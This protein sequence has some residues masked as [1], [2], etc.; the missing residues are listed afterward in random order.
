LVRISEGSLRI[1][2]A[3]KVVEAVGCEE[4]RGHY[5]GYHNEAHDGDPYKGLEPGAHLGTR[6]LL[7]PACGTE[8]GLIVQEL[9]EEGAREE[10]AS[11]QEEVQIHALKV[12][13]AILDEGRAYRPEDEE[14]HEYEV[15]HRQEEQLQVKEDERREASVLGLNLLLDLVEIKLL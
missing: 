12:L 14:V 15:E 8:V 10:D 6:R 9:P 1:E 5:H 7:E 11:E 2:E 13:L 4:L 3:H